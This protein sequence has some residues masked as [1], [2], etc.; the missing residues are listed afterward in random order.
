MNESN[1]DHALGAVILTKYN[2][3]KTAIIHGE[4]YT[5]KRYA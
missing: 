4:S 3:I 1:A 5:A 2:A